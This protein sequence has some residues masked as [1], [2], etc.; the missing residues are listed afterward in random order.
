MRRS[1]YATAGHG[2][3]NYY[4]LL[5]AGFQLL[6][7]PD[8]PPPT[9][10]YFAPIG[11]SREPHTRA[12]ADFIVHTAVAAHQAGIRFTGFARENTFWLRVGDDTLFPDG[13]FQLIVGDREYSF[14]VELDNSGQRIRSDSADAESWE[15]K[16]RLYEAFQDQCEMRFR[17][18]VITTRSAERLSHI[19]IRASELAKNPHRSL[20]YGVTLAQYLE[21]QNALTDTCFQNH[22]G[23][24]VSLV[25]F[26]RTDTGRWQPVRESPLAAPPLREPSPQEVAVC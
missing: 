15:R 6:H 25:E 1:Q 17:V 26:P 23:K 18:L 9:K 5:P 20:I 24:R 13:A 10:R 2:T 7:G 8:A 4:T 22:R 3:Q 11:F 12:L 16:I 19:L 21:Q 14:F